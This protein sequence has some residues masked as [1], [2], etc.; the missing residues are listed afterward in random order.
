MG[1][2]DDTRHGREAA[3]R[4][5]A[6]D[7]EPAEPAGRTRIESQAAKQS[8]SGESAACMWSELG[9]VE[10]KHLDRTEG[11]RRVTKAD[12]TESQQT[13]TSVEIAQAT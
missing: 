7:L 2:D 1:L 3:D 9:D 5:D 4:A 13:M 8:R 12:Y 10:A 11:A 6:E